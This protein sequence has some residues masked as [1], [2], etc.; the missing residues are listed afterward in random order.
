MRRFFIALTIILVLAQPI[1]SWA[2]EAATSLDRLEVWIWPDYDRP[3]ALVLL[4]GTLPEGTPIPASVTIPIPLE[5]DVNA[6][7]R[8]DLTGSMY[9][10]EF[11]DSVPGQLTLTAPDPQFRVEYY[12]PYV[13][14]G[15]DRSFTFSWQSDMAVDELSTE[16]QQPAFADDMILFPGAK[17]ISTKE[18]GLQ[19]HI[20]PTAEIASGELFEFDASY[21]LSSQKLTA[22]PVPAQEVELTGPDIEEAVDSGSDFNLLL[23]IGV[24]AAV[25]IIAAIGWLVYSG[26]SGGGRVVK[27]RPLRQAR[28]SSPKTSPSKTQRF[29]H[30]CGEPLD[31]ED[32]FCRNCGT[33]V[34]GTSR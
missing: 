14:E 4:T 31:V 2:Q 10:I 5:A 12:Y 33:P 16:V 32:R 28:K 19:Y 13:A 1:S 21:T 11:D 7:A 20:L 9:D 22:D 30:E 3:A 25:L 18:D 15:N 8:I 24:T 27:P 6:V 17:E 23:A 34:K 29:C 26:R